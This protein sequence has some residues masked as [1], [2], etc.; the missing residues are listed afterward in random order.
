MNVSE[1]RNAILQYIFKNSSASIEELKDIFAIS[2]NTVHR[3]LNYLAK[4]GFIHKVRGGGSINSVGNFEKSFLYRSTQN[5]AEK[6]KIAAKAASLIRDGNSILLDNSTTA[7]YLVYHLRKFKNLTVFTYFQEIVAE[8]SK[9]IY[10]CQ[11]ICLGGEYSRTHNG[12]VGPTVDKQLM[13][14]N[15]DLAFICAAAIDPK[16]GIMQHQID[17]CIR[18]R[19]I[20]EAAS[21]THLLID[22]SKLNKRALF[23]IAP[24]SELTSMIINRPIVAEVEKEL[25]ETGITLRLV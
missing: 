17:E 16:L 18:K 23:S 24:L 8:L 14:L 13:Q 21:E 25:R 5:V 15:V 1:R 22:N 11:L 7:F 12:Y 2:T 20:I 9:S 4:Q 6:Q 10:D 3:D 19:L